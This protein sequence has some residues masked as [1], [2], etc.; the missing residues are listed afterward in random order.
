M[1]GVQAAHAIQGLMLMA[2]L[3]LDAPG[4]HLMK[5]LKGFSFLIHVLTWG[6]KHACVCMPRHA[7]THISLWDDAGCAW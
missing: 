7:L 2:R 3:V 4:C 6:K 5:Q 1:Y